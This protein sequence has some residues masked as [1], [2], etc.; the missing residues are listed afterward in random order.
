M[1]A[2]EEW[3]LPSALAGGRIFDFFMFVSQVLH[4]YGRGGAYLSWTVGM[5]CC[6]SCGDIVDEEDQ[7]LLRALWSRS[8]PPVSPSARSA[9]IPIAV[10][11]FA[12]ARHVERNTVPRVYACVPIAASGSATTV[13]KKASVDRVTKKPMKRTKT[14]IQ[15]TIS[16]VKSPVPRDSHRRS[17]PAPPP[18]EKL[19]QRL[20]LSPTAWAKL[21]YL[22]DAGDSEVGSF[23]I[24]AAEDLLYIEDVELVRQTCD[25][26]SVAF[27]DQAVADYFDRQVDAGRKVCQVGR[28]WVHTHPGSCPLPSA[29]DEETF[30]RVFDRSDWAIMFIL[31]RGGQAFAR[32]EFHIGPGGSLVLPVEVD[33]SRPFPA[34]DDRAWRKSYLAN[35]QVEEWPP[36]ARR[37]QPLGVGPADVS[38]RLV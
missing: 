6:D 20:R 13:L 34:S 31:A 27:D 2:K 3:R 1:K 17:P 14:M 22:R 7:L 24:S 25:I 4:T 36:A 28:I 19:P 33:Y 10:N 23:G 32:L 5:A 29:K 21:L 26:A 11:A 15:Q 9:S 30:T 38:G 8:A 12:S 16:S 37:R 35:V 18:N